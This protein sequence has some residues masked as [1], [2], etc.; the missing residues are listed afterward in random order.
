MHRKMVSVIEQLLA[1][2]AN[3]TILCNEGDAAMEGFA[4]R[5]CSL[6]K[7][8]CCACACVCC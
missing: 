3:L 4:A 7:V 8:R 5:G 1:R 6:I 2:S